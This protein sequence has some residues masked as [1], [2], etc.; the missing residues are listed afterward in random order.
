MKTIE[1]L[2]GDMQTGAIP[3]VLKN[4][5]ARDVEKSAQAHRIARSLLKLNRDLVTKGGR[6]L[7]VVKRGAIVAEGA[8]E[9]ETV[10]TYNYTAYSLVTINP[11]KTRVPI[12]VTQESIDAS[13]LDVIRGNI[14]EAGLALADK[15]DVD[16]LTVLLAVGTAQEIAAAVTGTTSRSD[17]VKLRTKVNVAKFHVK[18]LVLHP[19]QFEDVLNDASFYDTSKYGS[20]EPIVNGE[21]GSI[22]GMKVLVS[23]NMTSGK[24]LAVDPRAAVLA[25]KRDL[26]L[27]RKDAPEA[28]STDL[29]FYMEYKPGIVNSGAIAILTGA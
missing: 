25:I 10:S 16:I 9:G 20:R 4:I 8:T 29:Y 27:K 28:D 26:D 13:E 22:Y 6:A 5:V 24:V 19:D 7:Y 18:F 14:E 3:A 17:L 1:Q 15:E 2:A 12:R 23:E 11:T 21:V